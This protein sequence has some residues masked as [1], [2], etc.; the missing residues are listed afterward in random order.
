[1]SRTLLLVVAAVGIS[2]AVLL[3]F[4]NLMVTVGSRFFRPISL[5]ARLYRPEPPVQ[6][7]G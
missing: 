2:P 1:M 7:Y 6:G 3:A 5:S 4:V